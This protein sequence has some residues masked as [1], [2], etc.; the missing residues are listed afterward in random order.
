MISV[1]TL[2]NHGK[3]RLYL[4]IGIITKEDEEHSNHFHIIVVFYLSYTQEEDYKELNRT[5][6]PT[7]YLMIQNIGCNHRKIQYRHHAYTIVTTHP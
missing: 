3:T 4:C 1:I 2:G 6:T 5:I 7:I